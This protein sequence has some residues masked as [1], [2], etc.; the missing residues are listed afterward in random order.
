[1]TDLSIIIVCHKG[2][3][4]LYKCLDSLNTFSGTGFTAEVVVVDNKSDDETIL[5]IE[6]QFPKFSFIR[7]SVNGGYANGCNLGSR[8]SD[9]EFILILNP[10]TVVTEAEIGNLLNVARQNPD[11]SIVSCRQVNEKGR[12]CVAYGEFPSVYNLTGFQRALFR[13]GRQVKWKPDDEV[14]FPD[15]IPGSVV[16]VKRETYEK[17]GG[18]DEDFWMYYE[19]V[20]LCKRAANINGKTAF[21]RNITIE[22][23][24]GGSSRINIRTTSLTKTEVHISRHVY[25]SKNKKGMERT[26]I[27]AFLVINN[28]LS[29]GIAAIPGLLFFFHPKMFSRT[30]IYIRLIKYYSGSLFRLSWISPMS[31][32][33]RKNLADKRV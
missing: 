9:G 16:L 28:L 26:L 24:H 19:D 2:W 23:N 15:W 7:N 20:D 4:R 1:M 29:A 18:L 11:Y 10:D 13:R 25:I 14:I 21:C 5:L 8:N 12:E 32:N 6:K 33:F 30:I 31:V 3:E 22:H 17:L 27:Q